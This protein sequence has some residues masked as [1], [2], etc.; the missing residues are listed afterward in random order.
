[1]SD[2]ADENLAERLSDEGLAHVWWARRM[3]QAA[4]AG[5]VD[6]VLAPLDAS[7]AE[8]LAALSDCP[9]TIEELD[10]LARDSTERWIA[11]VSDTVRELAA[12][13]ER[14]ASV[15]RRIF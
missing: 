1:M 2:A 8:L 11:A 7:R 6:P 14:L 3:K 12:N 10:E 4:D 15:E 5:D 13:P 9:V